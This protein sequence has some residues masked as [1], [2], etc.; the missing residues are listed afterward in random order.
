MELHP[1]NSNAHDD[2][3][4]FCTAIKDEKE[5]G[6]TDFYTLYGRLADPQE[7]LA[8]AI[9]DIVDRREALCVAKQLATKHGLPL[10]APLFDLDN[11]A[12]AANVKVFDVQV[13][14]TIT[15]TI[16]VV[17]ESD[18]DLSA[19]QKASERFRMDSDN[20]PE[21]YNQETIGVKAV[22]DVL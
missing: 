5:L 2:G 16:S 20:T 13:Q 22:C 14:A 7:P 19:I 8:E 21:I 12:H 6:K 10:H 1:V 11:D 3:S 15:K 9:T 4:T 17:A 18:D